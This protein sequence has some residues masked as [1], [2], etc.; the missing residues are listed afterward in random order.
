M[1]PT[2]ASTGASNKSVMDFIGNSANYVA[3]YLY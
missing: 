2:F 3:R 1:D